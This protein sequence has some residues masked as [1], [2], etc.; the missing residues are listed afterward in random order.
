MPRSYAEKYL[1]DIKRTFNY[2]LS[3]ARRYVECSFGILSN[4]WRIFYLPIDVNAEFA[5]DIIKC[6]CLL[7]NFVYDHEGLKFEDMLTITGM[8]E[9]EHDHN[10]CVN[11]SVNRYWD[12]LANYFVFEHRQLSWKIES[13]LLLL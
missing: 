13:N 8:E 5:I 4:K 10:L 2:R 11:W 12:A 6:C 7:H 9:L 1:Q 3:W